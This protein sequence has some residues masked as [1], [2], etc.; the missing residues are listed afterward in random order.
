VD[1]PFDLASIVVSVI[2]AIVVVL[3]VSMFTGSR[4]RG[5]NAI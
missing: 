4:S 2:G 3:V 5:S 1:G